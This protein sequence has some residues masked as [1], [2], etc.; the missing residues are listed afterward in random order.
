MAVWQGLYVIKT[1]RHIQGVLPDHVPNGVYTAHHRPLRIL[2][3]LNR[4]AIRQSHHIV[5]GEVVFLIIVFCDRKKG[6]ST[7]RFYMDLY[8]FFLPTSGPDGLQLHGVI[9]W[10]GKK[11]REIGRCSQ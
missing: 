8:R 6:L 4:R 7:E 11:I 2:S 5:Y 10:R 3:A 1:T 9:T